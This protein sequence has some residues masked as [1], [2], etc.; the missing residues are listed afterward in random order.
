MG[1]LLDLGCGKVPLYLIY[2]SHITDSIC[3]DWGNSLHGNDYIDSE[4]DLLMFT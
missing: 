3:V 2:K 1:Y 4:C